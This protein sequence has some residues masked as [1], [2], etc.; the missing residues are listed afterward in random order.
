MV[1]VC[2]GWVGFYGISTTVGYLIPNPFFTYN[3]FY[4]K[5]ISLTLVHCFN[6]K[7]S[8]ISSNQFSLSTQFS[9]IWS[10]DRTQSGATTPGQSCPV[11]EGNDRILCIPQSSSIT[12]TLPSDCLMSYL[13]H[14]LRES[15]SS[16]EKQSVYSTAPVDSAFSSN[17]LLT[18]CGG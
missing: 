5:Q 4:F 1:T 9:S 8:S 14:S 17:G 6:V 18:I 3:Q 2:F 7:S 13:R 11:S 16:R 10:R 15:Y 12:R